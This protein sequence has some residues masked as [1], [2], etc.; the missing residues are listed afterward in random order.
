[1]SVLSPQPT[2]E[3]L[4]AAGSAA[5]MAASSVGAKASNTVYH[6]HAP[7]SE[8]CIEF[9]PDV[10]VVDILPALQIELKTHRV[11]SRV[12]AAGGGAT[13]CA[14][15]LRYVAYADWDS[16]PFESS[17]RL[18]LRNAALTLQRADGRVLSHSQYDA[19]TGVLSGKWAPTRQ[20]LA[21]VV[22]ALI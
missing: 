9:N 7:V 6:F 13:G 10:P 15:W 22:T 14:H 21:P 12:Y 19:G 1:C 4:K 20:K 11:D 3:L 18:Y 2:W 5:T 17:K 8:V 16:P